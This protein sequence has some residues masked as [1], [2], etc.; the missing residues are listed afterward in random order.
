VA[1][2]FDDISTQTPVSKRP[3]GQSRNASEDES[4]IIEVS[5]DED[6]EADDMDVDTA[7]DAVP[8]NVVQT[9]SFRDVGPLRDFP[10]RPNFQ[11]QMSVPSTPG[12]STPGGVTYEQ[13]MKE[14]EEMKRK[15]AER[16]AKKKVNGKAA[17]MTTND[18]AISA[19]SPTTTPAP[20]DEDATP[21]IGS[22]P[23]AT[24][25]LATLAT[26]PPIEEMARS[27]TAS[28][29]RPSSA[30]ALARQQEKER[31]RQRLLELERDEY[32]DLDEAVEAAAD[33]L[34]AKAVQ[35]LTPTPVISGA[36]P[37]IFSRDATTQ[38]ASAPSLE[39]QDQVAADATMQDVHSEDGELSE[40]SVSKFYGDDEEV[41]TGDPANVSQA[42]GNR[43]APS[44]PPTATKIMEIDENE[45]LHDGTV[46][47]Y[48]P[49]AQAVNSP[50]A[51][52]GQEEELE[53]AEIDESDASTGDLDNLDKQP[54]EPDVTP[55]DD[56]DNDS[57]DVDVSS[58]EDMDG[59]DGYVPEV[60][61]S[62]AALEGKDVAQAAISAISG[63]IATEP[64][65]KTETV[66]D[67]LAPELQPGDNELVAHPEEVRNTT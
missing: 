40:G 26:Q 15:I 35:Q 51:D 66:D 62:A 42:E 48:S 56:Q 61:P 47:P 11:K 54:M 21:T 30:T 1:S 6:A 49:Q 2:D 41:P 5:D 16:E 37:G 43:E 3:F 52:L 19:S 4:V 50:H 55:P 59:P 32:Q 60:H 46:T 38:S 27:R 33:M 45:Q 23:I 20:I 24:D 44:A 18:T 8:T 17:V 64:T 58:T 28:S 65:Y 13:R 25:T 39:A 22:V 31:L 57:D 36:L 9:K 12:G 53:S 29:G 34:E 67:D 63:A 14:I 7:A 10:P